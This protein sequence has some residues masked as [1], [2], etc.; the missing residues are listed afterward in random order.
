[1]EVSHT[2]LEDLPIPLFQAIYIYFLFEVMGEKTETLNIVF[3]PDVI[4]CG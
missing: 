1:M 3:S 4:L 2:Q